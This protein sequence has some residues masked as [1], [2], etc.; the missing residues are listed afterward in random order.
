MKEF[1]N[2]INLDEVFEYIYKFKFD[3]Y[4]DLL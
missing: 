1:F 4:G 3:R 2:V